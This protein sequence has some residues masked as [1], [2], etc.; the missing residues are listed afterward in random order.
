MPA[1]T[2]LS[3]YRFAPLTGLKALRT[4]L[5]ARCAAADL[6][7]TILLSPEGVNLFVAGGR[8][9]IDGL[10]A[11]LHG[12]PG[13]VGLEPKFSESAA[14]PFQRM[15]VKI[16]KEIIA[17]GVEGIDPAARPSPK[18]AAATL[19]QWLDEGRPVTLLDTRNDYEVQLGTFRGARPIG[20]GQFRE[21][22]AAVAQLPAELKEQPVVMFCTGGIRCEKAGPFMERAGFRQIFQLDGGILRYFEECGGAHFDGECFVF[23]QRVGVDPALRETGTAQCFH[24]QTPLTLAEQRD[25]R[26]RPPHACLF[27]HAI[28]AEQAAQNLATRHAALRR[29][30]TPLPGSQPYDTRR[31]LKIPAAC[32][33]LLLPD[34]LAR[35]F[36]HTARAEWLALCASGR[37]LHE[38]GWAASADTAVRAGERYLRLLPG[39]VEPEVNADIRILHEDEAVIV[40]HKPAPLPMHPGGRYQRHTLRH[41]LSTL[42]A[43]ESPRPAHRLEADTSGVVVFAR[44]RHFAG[45]LQ[46][47][48]AR[49]EVEMLSLARVQGHPASDRFVCDTPISDLPARTEGR[50]LQR[51]PDGTAL[52]AVHPRT[53][54]PDQIRVH[55]RQVGLPVFGD[56]AHL[57]ERVLGDRQTLP[58]L[59]LQ[60][61]RLTF[62]HPLTQQPVTFAAERPAWAEG[63]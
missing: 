45:L 30:T 8:A 11:E 3:A 24:C 29:L 22:P 10:L 37:L 49:G 5:L 4:R 52:L 1:V 59:C 60:A 20:I 6:R 43:P 50:T 51:F 7:G 38:L 62:T 35:I 9:E 19:R 14:Q 61:A 27:C 21:F 57:P 26:F 17:F 55:L 16:K 53:D 39:A 13:L 48:F 40:V 56:P 25:P 63:F 15:L 36:P 32:D 47:Q 34:A 12:V 18:I 33:G 2:N 42:Y 41:F 58:P 54:H 28:P 31:P 44:T 23:D 46:P